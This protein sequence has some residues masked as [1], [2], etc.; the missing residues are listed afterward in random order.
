M[1]NNLVINPADKFRSKSNEF[2][3]L[4]VDRYIFD[5]RENK[6]ISDKFFSSKLDFDYR[7]NN[8]NLSS[9]IFYEIMNCIKYELN[10][11]FNKNFDQKFYEIVIGSWL[12][13]FIQQFILK[14]KYY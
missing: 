14:Y 5:Q 2:I 12:R 11:L 13:K 9:A 6:K 8:F 4:Y 10:L 3:D 1:K 7:R